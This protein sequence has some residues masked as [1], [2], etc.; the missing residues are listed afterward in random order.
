MCAGERYELV[1]RCLELELEIQ[2]LN[3]LLGQYE[4]GGRRTLTADDAI[5]MCAMY[6]R[7]LTRQE[8]A[9]ATGWKRSTVYRVTR[10]VLI[11]RTV[12]D[13]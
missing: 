5:R 7:G 2:R 9:D 10:D 11:V 1:L 8:I 12:G 13:V 6:A 4:A 3:G